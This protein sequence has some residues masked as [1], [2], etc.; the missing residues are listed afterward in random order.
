MAI[1]K[2]VAPTQSTMDK[3]KDR[4]VQAMGGPLASK[5]MAD[6]EATGTEKAG[7]V[8]GAALGRLGAKSPRCFEIQSSRAQKR[9]NKNG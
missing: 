8:A 2:G 4:A 1:A 9:C 7:A 5:T 3:M 6:P